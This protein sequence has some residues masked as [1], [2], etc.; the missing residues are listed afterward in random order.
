MKKI[1]IVTIAV[2]ALLCGSQK[3][4]AQKSK[5]GHVDYAELVKQTPEYAVAEAQLKDFADSLQKEG[6][7]LKAEFE[8]KYNEFQE[9]ATT[10]S[11]AVRNVKQKEVED[12]YS[13]L[14]AYAQV[15]EE[16]L[17]DKNSSLLEPIQKKVMD[18]IKE[19]AKANGYTYIFDVSTQLYN[20]ESDDITNK[21]KEKLGV[22]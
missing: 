4:M 22:K 2:L 15:A 14:Q 10:Y 6:D 18:A 1:F 21:V 8:K 7:A 11:E 17:A 12:M 13:R 9:K 20:S 5:F 16:K 19:V 3:A